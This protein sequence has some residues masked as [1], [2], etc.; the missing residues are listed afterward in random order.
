MTVWHVAAVEL[1]EAGEEAAAQKRR[2]DPLRPGL[3]PVLANQEAVEHVLQPQ[4]RH[5]GG[6]DLWRQF[7]QAGEA[8]HLDVAVAEAVPD[9]EQVPRREAV[10]KG[11]E[12]LSPAARLGARHYEVVVCL[13]LLEL[14]LLR[15]CQG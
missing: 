15:V 1:Q 14:E 7:S 4:V 13:V 2:D 3:A 12:R 5:N 6:K 9:V 8:L 10:E 11:V